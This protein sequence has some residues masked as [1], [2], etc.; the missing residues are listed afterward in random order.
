VAPPRIAAT[1]KSDASFLTLRNYATGTEL[2]RA[3]IT[4]RTPTSF[5]LD[6]QVNTVGVE[7]VNF[8]I[9]KT[10]AAAPAPTI[11]ASGTFLN[12]HDQNDR[13]DGPA[14]AVVVDVTNGTLILTLDPQV[15]WD[16]IFSNIIGTGF[17]W[18]VLS[19]Q[20][21]PS[22][23]VTRES[24]TRVSI[25]VPPMATYGIDAQ[26]T[27]IYRLD[28]SQLD[29]YS[30]APVIAPEGWTTDVGPNMTAALAGTALPSMA[31]A[32]VAAGTKN[33]QIVLTNG[34]FDPA[35][36]KTA[37]LALFTGTSPDPA[38]WNALRDVEMSATNITITGNTAELDIDMP[39]YALVSG[40]ET[41]SSGDV[42]AAMTTRGETAAVSGSFDITMAV[43]TIDRKRRLILLEEGG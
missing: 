2:F 14:Q 9:G 37:I 5:D 7:Q 13:R 16:G 26:Q 28:P 17:D 18:S 43:A 3:V 31:D 41:V 15:I 4:N 23:L 19:N 10:S 27:Y 36:D 38:A 34:V 29:G 42:T 21:D 11:S 6:V 33:A 20:V 35:A 12:T 39:S 24:S 1:Y 22:G 8:W 32:E 40:N 25:V 30:G